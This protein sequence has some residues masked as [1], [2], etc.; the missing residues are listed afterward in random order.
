VTKE[1]TL[2]EL[3]KVLKPE[4]ILSWLQENIGRESLSSCTKC[5]IALYLQDK[6]FLSVTVFR[7]SLYTSPAEDINTTYEQS[8]FSSSLEIG[9]ILHSFISRYDHPNQNKDWN[10]D[11]IT[12]ETVLLFQKSCGEIF[13]V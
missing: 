5:P 1:Q 4:L 8:F 2:L 10:E 7:D 6:G 12:E 13:R 3:N 11:K 9:E